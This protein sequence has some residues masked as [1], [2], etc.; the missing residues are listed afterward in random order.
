MIGF[1]SQDPKMLLHSFHRVDLCLELDK[2]AICRT[3][4]LA[5]GEAGRVMTSGMSDCRDKKDKSHGYSN[6]VLIGSF[7]EPSLATSSACS[8]SSH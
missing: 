5:V 8:T 7:S 1:F 2:G 3:I 6:G 4:P